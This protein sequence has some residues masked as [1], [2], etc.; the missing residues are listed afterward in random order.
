MLGA[1]QE[2]L[3]LTIS[4]TKRTGKTF[5]HVDEVQ[6]T[7]NSLKNAEKVI[8]DKLA[9][10]AKTGHLTADQVKALKS[11]QEQTNSLGAKYQAILDQAN[12]I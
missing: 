11:A 7:I 12:E 3:G 6:G 10:H 4:A 8:A 9:H 1:V 5:D 2:I